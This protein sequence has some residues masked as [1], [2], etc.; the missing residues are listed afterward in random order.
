MWT[1]LLGFLWKANL[2]LTVFWLV[3]RLVLQKWTFYKLNRW[4]WILA[5]L[6]SLSY[7]FFP[8]LDWQSVTRPWVMVTGYTSGTAQ[9]GDFPWENLMIVL[10]GMSVLFFLLRTLWRFSSI[11]RIHKRSTLDSWEGFTFRQV[12]TGT[13]PFSF[14]QHIYLHKQGHRPEDLRR[15][16]LHESVHVKQ[17]HTL[18][19]LLL[20][21][22]FPLF[23]YNPVLWRLRKALY[24][25]LEFLT[26]NEVLKQGADRMHYQ[27]SL[28][29][30]GTGLQI[31]PGNAFT[32]GNLKKRILH[33]NREGTHFG[34]KCFYLML[35]PLMLGLWVCTSFRERQ[36]IRAITL[37]PE[38]KDQSGQ[39]HSP[40]IM[41]DGTPILEEE[42]AKIPPED[43]KAI[44]VLK[45]EK[46]TEKYGVGAENGILEIHMK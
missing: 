17:W 9:A 45:G 16:L 41:L 2:S 20:E 18:D 35:I 34:K 37:N 40:V 10:A 11:Y 15:I 7:A 21:L 19:C 22:I 26:D 42:M 36:A 27:Y 32:Y 14:F 8:A 31:S 4:Y 39:E 29:R 44:Y 28:L 23:W 30:V 33:M 3:Y 38:T 46:A 25:N 24:L 43:I 13:A 12:E 1:D 5:L 6:F